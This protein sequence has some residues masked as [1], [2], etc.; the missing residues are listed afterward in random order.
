M[1]TK[2]TEFISTT[3]NKSEKKDINVAI[4]IGLIQ[5]FIRANSTNRKIKV[6]TMIGVSRSGK[7]AFLN[8]FTTY[9]N[10]MAN[11]KQDMAPFKSLNSKASEGKDVTIGAN[12]YLFNVTND[13]S[14]LIIDIQGIA[15]Q[16]SAAD[17]LV[18]LFCY[19]IGDI[20][21][22]GIDK[23]L[24]TQ[25]LNLLT[26]IAAKLQNMKDASAL[27]KPHLIFRIYDALDYYDDKLAEQNFAVM[28][29]DR[30]DAVQGIRKAINELF[31][32]PER[33]IIWTERPDR[34]SLK[35]VDEGQVTK[36]MKAEEEFWRSCGLLLKI[37]ETIPTRTYFK[38]NDILTCAAAINNQSSIIRSSEFD[39]ASHINEQEIRW[40]IE[41]DKY[42][43]HPDKTSQ[44]P[45]E[46]KQPLTVNDC[47]EESYQKLT[48]RRTKIDALIGTFNSR[49]S[50]SPSNIREAGLSELSKL[51]NTRYLIA[52][53]IFNDY[54][55]VVFQNILDSYSNA[56]KSL[57]FADDNEFVKYD[58]MQLLKHVD[59]NSYNLA[60]H[61]KK[62]ALKQIG[63]I[64]SKIIADWKILHEYYNVRY[65]D[66]LTRAV[67]A[68]AKYVK[69]PTAMLNPY[70]KE[71]EMKYPDI[72]RDI[73]NK[74]SQEQVFKINK[75]SFVGKMLSKFGSLFKTDDEKSE[76]HS[77]E[78]DIHSLRIV[79][80][81]IVKVTDNIIKKYVF[82]TK[83]DEEYI[84]RLLDDFAVILKANE[85]DFKEA[86]AKL[87]P[88]LLVDLNKTP[89]LN[90]FV[91]YKKIAH[92]NLY[93]CDFALNEAGTQLQNAYVPF[94]GPHGDA[95]LPESY[96]AYR[97]F[98]YPEYNNMN[99]MT[100]EQFEEHFGPKFLNLYQIMKSDKPETEMMKYI[101][102]HIYKVWVDECL[103]D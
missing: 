103:F 6:L 93:F 1:A 87:I 31:I 45:D 23:Q 33:K 30:S 55:K 52:L 14:Y 89:I 15:G 24:N 99:I 92:N 49:F 96:Q 65:T 56:W 42:G 26:P 54:Y 53:N 12:G 95:G 73:H 69:Q 70:L 48:E 57:E 36:F 19:Y 71:L 80:F 27:H 43:Q 68:L 94:Q 72:I 85:S 102:H 77:I 3:D 16:F 74:L 34:D 100:W 63:D 39:L 29:E 32:L 62:D 38:L 83:T 22:L 98:M 40:W 46:L 90:R 88:K 60:N 76:S 82:L 67:A 8:C 41:G 37:V 78:V 66:V 28:M 17:P 75:I 51:I 59:I 58:W 9:L 47:S 50:K 79:N 101:K 11:K 25:A 86:R 81:K 97:V 64:I 20:I 44:I 35:L 18:L 84:N 4:N 2:I 21:I 7:S 5:E 10:H 13:M 91:V 61:L